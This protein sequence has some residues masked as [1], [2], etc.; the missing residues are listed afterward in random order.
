MREVARIPVGDR[1]AFV[2]INHILSKMELET[3]DTCP[4]CSMYLA[5]PDLPGCICEKTQPLI[6][7]RT[8][9]ADVIANLRKQNDR[10]RGSASSCWTLEAAALALE[11]AKV[12]PRFQEPLTTGFGSRWTRTRG[13]CSG[14]CKAL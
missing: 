8:P 7:F 9:I 5:R 6:S 10:P 11:A 12:E 1:T 2:A 3:A 4:D 13:A 14:T